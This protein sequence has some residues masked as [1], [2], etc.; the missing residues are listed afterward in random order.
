M[1]YVLID[2]L[3]ARSYLAHRQMSVGVEV[4]QLNFGVASQSR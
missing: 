2:F 3:G 1:R 4:L